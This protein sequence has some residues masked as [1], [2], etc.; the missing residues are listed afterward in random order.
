M[1][2]LL[3][4]G[5]HVSPSRGV[6]TLSVCVHNRTPAALLPYLL[7][8]VLASLSCVLVPY[9][10]SFSNVTV[11]L[12]QRLPLEVQMLFASP[13]LASSLLF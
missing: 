2:S 11:M 5:R 13:L 1:M 7:A 10:V 3:G 12:P 4:T 6:R 8:S 9:Y